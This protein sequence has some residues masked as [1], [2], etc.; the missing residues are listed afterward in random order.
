MQFLRQLFGFHYSPP[1]K[2]L[3]EA[4]SGLMPFLRIHI[5]WPCGS[6]IS[7]TSRRNS[8]ILMH[9]FFR[10]LNIFLPSEE[11]AE[12]DSDFATVVKQIP[13][14]TI[15]KTYNYLYAPGLVAVYMGDFNNDGIPDFMAIKKDGGG[16]AA[17]WRTGV[18]DFSGGGGYHFTRITAMGLGPHN[19]VLDP[20]TKSFR[21]IHTSDRW[22]ET[23]DGKIHKLLGASFF[24]MGW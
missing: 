3:S 2:T 22:G 4:Q 6:T 18:F 14:G 13:G 16:F 8:F 21:L 20:K 7:H 24:Q 12:K 10:A 9:L 5:R 11:V 19:I 1:E 23:L 15:Y 17:E